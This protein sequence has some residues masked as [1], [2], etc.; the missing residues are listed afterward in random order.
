ML[1]LVK[2]FTVRNSLSIPYVVHFMNEKKIT[3][4]NIFRLDN[5]NCGIS[6]IQKRLKDKWHGVKEEYE[7]FIFTQI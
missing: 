3:K 2:E 7:P 6:D 4:K 5:L 1:P